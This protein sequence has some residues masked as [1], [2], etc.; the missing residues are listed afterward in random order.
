M[1]RYVENQPVEYQRETPARAGFSDTRDDPEGPI[2]DALRC[3]ETALSD[4]FGI[5][6]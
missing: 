2:A 1:E 4:N 6:R 5:H 3:Y